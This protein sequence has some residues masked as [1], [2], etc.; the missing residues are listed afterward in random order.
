MNC[1]NVYWVTEV[2][3]ADA[4][5]GEF[6]PDARVDASAPDGLAG[7]SGP[8]LPSRVAGVHRQG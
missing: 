5:G 4:D 1:P 2:G 7:L 8:S 3:E 6:A